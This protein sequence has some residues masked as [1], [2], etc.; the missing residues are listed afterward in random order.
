[1]SRKGVFARALR[2]TL[3]APQGAI[4]GAPVEVHKKYKAAHEC[5]ALVSGVLEPI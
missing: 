4:A 3:V 5:Q 2:L 1:M